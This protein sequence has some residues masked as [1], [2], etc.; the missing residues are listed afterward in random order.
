MAFTYGTA[1]PEKSAKQSKRGA[2]QTRKPDMRLFTYSARIQSVF[3][4]ACIVILGGCA[5]VTPQKVEMHDFRERA[6]HQQVSGVEVAVSVLSAEESEEEFGAPLASQHIQPV[7]LE[8]NN[9][10]S[11][12][13]L[14]MLLSVDPN[15]YSPSEVAWQMRSSGVYKDFIRR[16]SDAHIPIYIPARSKRTGFVYTNLDPGAKS[17]TVQLIGEHDTRTFEFVLLVPDFKADFDRVNLDTLY[18]PGVMRDLDLNG[19]RHYLE[20]LPC[21]VT[22]G[23]RKTPGDPLNLVVI[24]D[25]LHL[26]GTFVRQGWDLT[27]TRRFG[28]VWSTIS[29][30]LFG[31]RYRTSPISPLYF[32]GRQQDAALQK[33]RQTVDER[34]HLRLWLAPVTF[35]GT[36]VWVGQVSRDTGIKLSSQTLVTHKIDPMVDEARL[37]VLLDIARSQYLGRIGFVQ[38][39]G[40]ATQDAPRYN[41][42]DDPYFTDGLR[43]ALFLSAKPHSYQE[44]EWLNWALLP[45]GLD[46]TTIPQVEPK[47]PNSMPE[48]SQ[49]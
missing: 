33:S 34:N 18:R 5:G 16:Y 45:S 14:L 35:E 13:Y 12:D 37:Y 48:A 44:I 1:L 27:E 3:L 39:V 38:G 43:V 49:P 9:D 7:W 19:L 30:S 21:C 15:Y 6:E 20:N 31:T 26:L 47:Q 36:S 23:D 40:A 32:F 28:T 10:T 22:G 29:S 41:Y 46:D 4:L 8:I 2:G 24:G 42:T 11:Q 17:V 25:G